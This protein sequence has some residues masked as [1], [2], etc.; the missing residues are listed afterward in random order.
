MTN[1]LTH[2]TGTGEPHASNHGLAAGELAIKQKATEHTT[3][4]SG[5][6]YYG[7]DVSDI[8][9]TSSTLRT[10]GIG[11]KADNGTTQSGV[12]L[13]GNLYFKDGSNMTIT[14]ATSGDVTTLTFAA[15]S[16]S[17]LDISGNDN[18]LVKMHGSDDIQ[19]TG[20]TIDDSNNITGVAG[21][22]ATGLSTLG[23][24]LPK[25]MQIQY[26]SGNYVA[27]AIEDDGGTTITTAG[28]DDFLTFVS[29]T[30]TLDA[31]G[32]ITL[33]ADGGC[34]FLKNGGTTYWEFDHGGNDLKLTAGG[35]NFEIENAG[36]FLIDSAGNFEVDS[37][38]DIILDA[39]GDEIYLK[40]GGTE[41]FKFNLDST[42]E[43]DVTGAFTIDCS[44]GITLDANAGSTAVY[45]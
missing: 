29:P 37:E 2:Q 30:I 18:R 15:A 28:D 45:N 9:S 36:T 43:L 33:D 1:I 27:Y 39:A 24:A 14:Q 26:D 10:F 42:P 20:I 34:L 21:L 38:G 3:A 7:E 16:G 8:D 32:D 44:A 40:D 5:K 6:L 22:T 35:S 11:T 13:G 23:G 4:A 31:A 17:G 12:P 41:R 25:Q 19:E